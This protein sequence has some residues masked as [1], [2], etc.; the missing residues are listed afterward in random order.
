MILS[1]KS[2]RE[3]SNASTKTSTSHVAVTLTAS[4]L[5]RISTLCIRKG[6]KSCSTDLRLGYGQRIPKGRQRGGSV[7][8]RGIDCLF[9]VKISTITAKRIKGSM[10]TRGNPYFFAVAHNDCRLWR[11][12]QHMMA[13]NLRTYSPRS[14][15]TDET[16]SAADRQQPESDTRHRTSL[17]QRARRNPSR[18]CRFS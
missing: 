12:W 17:L 14:I 15:N 4:A 5:P 10:Y 8:L 13:N 2:F 9:T 11:H 16:S 1:S 18:T 7:M 3:P 6:H